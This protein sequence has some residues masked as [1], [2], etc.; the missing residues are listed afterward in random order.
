MTER[1]HDDQLDREVRRYLAWQS[2][3]VAGAP[4][5]AAVAAELA[6]RLGTGYATPR[7]TFGMRLPI[8]LRW[9]VLLIALVAVL[10]AGGLIGAGMLP[11]RDLAQPTPS[12]T[13][14]VPVQPSA[15]PDPATVHSEAVFLRNGAWVD[16]IYDVV[17]VAIDASGRER[18]VA[19]IPATSLTLNGP[20]GA[21]APSGMLALASGRGAEQR[22]TVQWLLIDLHDQLADPIVVPG[23]VFYEQVS[24]TPYYLASGRGGLAWGP[25]DRL[26]VIGYLSGGGAVLTTLSYVDAHTGRSTPV[27]IPNDMFIEPYWAADGSGMYVSTPRAA[28][29]PPA[30]PLDT[31]LLS[32]GRLVPMAEDLAVPTCR[33]DPSLEFACIAPDGSMLF[34][35][36]AGEGPRLVILSSDTHLQVE[37]RFAG[38]LEVIR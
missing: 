24:T 17:V 22:A 37:G 26:A 29:G 2:E 36:D 32:D 30:P 11:P 27:D 28:D 16:G 15:T 31:V 35:F 25:D 20:W 9:T 18:H 3:D 19:T 14:W 1:M 34:D 23:W 38:W 4:S 7:W 13:T 6:S 8:Q 10:A 5:R 12:P 21:V 33:R